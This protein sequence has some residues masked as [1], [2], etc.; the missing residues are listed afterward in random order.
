MI[1]DDEKTL[2][3]MDKC[4]LSSYGHCGLDWTTTLLDNHKEILI[5][6]AFS[7][8]RCFY[9]IKTFNKKFD[10]E[11]KDISNKEISKEFSRLFKKDPR[12]NNQKRKFLFKKKDFDAFETYLTKWL[13]YSKIN[14]I[15]KKIFLGIHYAFSKV[16]KIDLKK[17]KIL[18]AQEHVPFYSNRYKK[19]LNPKFL[20]IV[21]DPRATMAGAILRM[22]K[23][24]SDKIFSN[25][26][27][28]IILYCK[29]AEAFVNSYAQK[30]KIYVI[31]NEKMHLNLKKEMLKLSKWLEIN[32]S[33]TMLQQTIQG[34]VWYG[35]SSYLQGKNQDGDLKKSP[36][37]N[38]YDSN[39][40]KK[41]WKSQ[42]KE[43]DILMIEVI[44]KDVFKKFGYNFSVK[45]NFF[46]YFKTYLYLF[47]NFNYQKKYFISKYLII[48]RNIIR[49]LFIL[50]CPNH[51]NLIYKFH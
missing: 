51:V 33:K 6:P 32:Y 44:F 12:Q 27:D 15:Y 3:K 42:L 21:R 19:I 5:M 40:I 7:F 29:S 30:E 13:N 1:G 23:H 26:F 43:I 2:E 48:P 16:Y 10:V 17:K 39:Q 50:I 37:K 18:V 24:N 31:Q 25:Q 8:F 34:K 49:R 36:P 22:E 28:H 46:D 14:N 45:K 9:Y 11:N 35:E 47:F 41:R 20:Y 38:F 4:I